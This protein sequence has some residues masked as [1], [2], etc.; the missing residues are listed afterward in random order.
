MSQSPA[1][2]PGPA[3][4]CLVPPGN[5][6]AGTGRL[7]CPGPVRPWDTATWEGGVGS[8]LPMGS[9]VRAVQCPGEQGE[10]PVRCGQAHSG[11]GYASQAVGTPRW[12]C[13]PYIFPSSFPSQEYQ[14]SPAPLIE[15]PH[16]SPCFIEDHLGLFPASLVLH[17][18]GLRKYCG[19]ADSV[20][21][22]TAWSS[23]YLSHSF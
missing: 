9:C 21:C 18:A 20:S 4:T 1:G 16:G 23:D 14:A 7:F 13:L 2:S 3:N 12:D 15:K 10:L 19:C 22:V 8:C 6:W 5:R 17:L 11:L